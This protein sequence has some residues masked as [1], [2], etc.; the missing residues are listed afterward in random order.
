MRECRYTCACQRVLRVLA[1]NDDM[2]FLALACV[3]TNLW[4]GS[5]HTFYMASSSLSLLHSYY[6]SLLCETLHIYILAGSFF[7]GKTVDLLLAMIASWKKPRH[8]TEVFIMLII[9]SNQRGTLQP[10]WR[11]QS[12]PAQG[13]SLAG[14][15]NKHLKK[16]LSSSWFKMW[17]IYTQRE[18]VHLVLKVWIINRGTAS[19]SQAS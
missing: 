12:F 10:P 14:A 8:A 11:A 16:M 2:L 6:C 15:S 19:F 5:L 18:N 13:L 4:D 9:H 3:N 1:C 7:K 17:C